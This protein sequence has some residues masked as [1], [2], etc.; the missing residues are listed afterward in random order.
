MGKTKPTEKPNSNSTIT[1]CGRGLNFHVTMMPYSIFKTYSSSISMSLGF[2]CVTCLLGWRRYCWTRCVNRCSA[3][4]KILPFIRL[5]VVP[6]QC[7]TYLCYILFFF[8]GR[9]VKDCHPAR[10]A[11]RHLGAHYFLVSYSSCPP[12]YRDPWYLAV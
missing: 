12:P 6:T 2:V 1:N 7:T 9:N 10:L 5:K 11:S 3:T 8:I 4:L